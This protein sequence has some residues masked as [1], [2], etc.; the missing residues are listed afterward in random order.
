MSKTNFMIIEF[1]SR[2]NKYNKDT[3]N[4]NSPFRS[5][6]H[7]I[8]SWEELYFMGCSVTEHC[9]EFRYSVNIF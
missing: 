7:V 3:V 2:E 6:Y 1:H 4:D 9:V 8:I 5:T